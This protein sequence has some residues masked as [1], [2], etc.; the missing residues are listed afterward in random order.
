MLAPLAFTSRSEFTGNAKLSRV[1]VLHISIVILTLK[2]YFVKDFTNWPVGDMDHDAIV[3]QE[4]QPEDT[5]SRSD[6]QRSN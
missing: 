4:Y 3:N 6:H 2:K 5:V 1:K